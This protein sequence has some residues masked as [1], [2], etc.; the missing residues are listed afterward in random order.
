MRERRRWRRAW[1]RRRGWQDSQWEGW[2]AGGQLYSRNWGGRG[3]R[4]TEEE[5]LR[6]RRS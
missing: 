1:E 3:R 5:M 2:R 6:G 4:M